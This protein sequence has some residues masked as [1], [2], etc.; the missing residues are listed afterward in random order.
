MTVFLI[1]IVTVT[2]LVSVIVATL[3]NESNARKRQ[4]LRDKY[5]EPQ[6]ERRVDYVDSQ[7][8]A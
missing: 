7:Q 4:T 5:S 1:G 2:A 8:A 3:A 6:E